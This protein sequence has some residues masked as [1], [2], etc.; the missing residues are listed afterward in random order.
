MDFSTPTARWAALTTR[1]RYA[2]PHFVYAV[3]T[4][5]IY[6][7]PSCAARLARRANV[8]FYNTPSLAA[9]AGFRACKRCKPDLEPQEDPQDVAVAK[10][11]DVIREAEYAGGHIGLNE[12]AERVGLTP[13]YLHK[14]FKARMG[15]TPKAYAEGLSVMVQ[16]EKVL[17]PDLPDYDDT[18]TTFAD[19]GMTGLDF[20]FGDASGLDAVSDTAGLTLNG[21]SEGSTS[22]STPMTTDWSWFD[23]PEPALDNC[24]FFDAEALAQAI[25]HQEA[26]AGWND[27]VSIPYGMAWEG[28]PD[29]GRAQDWS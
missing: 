1:N 18:Y 6:C 11:C 13:S 21:F 3:K 19:T 16:S 20:D 7:R 25:L 23:A 26:V 28:M 24:V 27:Q 4:T 5:K 29:V 2:D 17:V 8:E 22:I 14:T 9:K 15:V 10:A 12:L